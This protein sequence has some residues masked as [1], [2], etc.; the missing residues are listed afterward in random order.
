MP[1]GDADRSD[2]C[3]PGADADTDAGTGTDLGARRDPAASP[4]VVTVGAATVDRTYHVSNIPGADGG[5]Y[6][7]TVAESF[8]GVGANV[9]LA[10]ARL[11]RSA[12]LVARLGDDDV[13]ARVATDLDGSPV[14]D[15]RVRRE[16]GT[17]THCVIL[18]DDTGKRSIVTAGDSASRLR[19]DDADRRYLSGAE[20]V[21]LTAYNPDPVHRAA[22]E[23]AADTDAP[24]TVFDLS[25]RLAELAGRGASE[26]TVD[27]WVETADLFVVGDVAAESYLGCTGRE[28]AAELRAR[29]AD[30]VAATSGPDGAVLADHTGLHEL[31][32]VAV[33]AVDETGAGDAYVAALIDRWMLSDASAREAGRFAAAAAAFNVASEGARGA[34]ATRADVESLLADR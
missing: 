27:R 32:A 12:G 34:L 22:L 29:G 17:S 33:D 16:P 31:S 1:D 11:G 8:G 20:A 15:A 18:R 23:L 21:F 28:A 3:D 7:G 26:A 30:R 6:A 2:T 14:D 5:A 13:G 10:A 25:G 19:L 24:P 9:A 4:A